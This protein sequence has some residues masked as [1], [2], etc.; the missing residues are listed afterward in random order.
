VLDPR[1]PC[2]LSLPRPG[3]SAERAWEAWP[4]TALTD[5]MTWPTF[6]RSARS[7]WRARPRARSECVPWHGSRWLTDGYPMAKLHI[8]DDPSDGA[9]PATVWPKANAVDRPRRGPH[10]AQC[11]ALVRRVAL[12]V[13]ADDW[14]TR[15]K[16][17]MGSIHGPRRTCLTWS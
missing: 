5:R 6:V 9:P 15:A 14:T 16:M 8:V 2:T 4:T 10:G 1:A 12:P 3:H 7:V 11:E 17:S 13:T